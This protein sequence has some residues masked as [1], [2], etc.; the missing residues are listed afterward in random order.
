M[1]NPRIDPDFKTLIPPLTPEEYTLLEQ[2]IQS[3]GCREPVL[4]WRGTIV[5]GHNRHEICTKHGLEYATATLRFATK[6]E[7]KLWILNN[8]LGRRNLTD[9]A[10]IE[11]TAAKLQIAAHKTGHNTCTHKKIAEALDISEKTVQRYMKIK[12]KGDPKLLEDVMTGRLKIGT[13]HQRIEV[14][15]ITREDMGVKIPPGDMTEVYTRAVMSNVKLIRNLYVFLMEN[16]DFMG[17]VSC[18]VARRVERQIERVGG[19][20]NDCNI[21][22]NDA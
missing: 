9:A 14:T 17:G 1:P 19:L 4:L 21:C 13:A 22:I 18:E 10:R 15:T 6:E 3:Q 16:R 12:A 5:D 7:A 8:Q 11:L 20:E 2:N